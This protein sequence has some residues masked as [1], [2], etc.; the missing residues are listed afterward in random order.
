MTKQVVTSVT[1]TVYGMTMDRTSLVFLSRRGVL[2]FGDAW[3]VK[4][5]LEA[6]VSTLFL[7]TAIVMKFTSFFTLLALFL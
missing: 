2:D 4:E 7:S 5:E 6:V 3:V 1:A